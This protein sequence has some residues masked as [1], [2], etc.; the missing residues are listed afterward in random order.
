MRSSRLMMKRSWFIGCLVLA[1]SS[2][3]NLGEKVEIEAKPGKGNGTT[4]GD[5]GDGGFK[6][7]A[8]ASGAGGLVGHTG[9]GSAGSNDGGV[10]GLP[11]GGTGGIAPPDMV[12]G[13]SPG[14]WIDGECW[15]T[16]EETSTLSACPPTYCEARAQMVGYCGNYVQNRRPP[17]VR[18]AYQRSCGTVKDVVVLV[19]AYGY[20]CR[21]AANT[22]VGVMQ[23]DNDAYYCEGRAASIQTGVRLAE[24]ASSRLTFCDASSGESGTAGSSNIGAAGSSSV[25][26][27]G[28]SGTSTEGGQAGA[29]GSPERP[30]GLCYDVATDT[31]QPC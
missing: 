10:V 8:A 22:L 27:A 23:Y 4:G 21:Y 18:Y 26:V 5:G 7:S 13:G 20:S 29:A 3:Q 12:G 30:I 9:S 15:G 28:S 17:I 19:A 1:C 6:D 24:C 25:G 2:M 31:C 14:T 11:Q 16:P